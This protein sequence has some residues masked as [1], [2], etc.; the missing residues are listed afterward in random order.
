MYE[1]SENFQIIMKKGTKNK[2]CSHISAIK[3]TQS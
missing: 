2:N 1:D 3:T